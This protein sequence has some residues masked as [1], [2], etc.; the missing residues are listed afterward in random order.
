MS[1]SGILVPQYGDIVYKF[2]FPALLGEVAL[3][4]WLLIMGIKIPPLA[5]MES[6]RAHSI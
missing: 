3:T 2:A 4:L 1:L 5:G 6:S